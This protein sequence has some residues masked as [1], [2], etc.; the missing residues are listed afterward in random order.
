MVIQ[1]IAMLAFSLT[2]QLPDTLP[3]MPPGQVKPGVEIS[4]ILTY[5]GVNIYN[6]AI[7]IYCDG[8]ASDTFHVKKTKP[9]FVCL[10]YGHQYAIR[11][12]IEG[13]RER[14]VMINTVVDPVIAQKI[15]LFDYEIEMVRINEPANTFNDLPVAIVAYDPAF[16]KFQF[17]QKYH[18]QVR[19]AGTVVTN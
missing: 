19:E 13:F 7:V 11:Y 3:E 2:A 14:V 12:V 16:K 4:S 5:E 8:K 18:E 17:S 10:D 9:V 1:S 15:M 6:Y